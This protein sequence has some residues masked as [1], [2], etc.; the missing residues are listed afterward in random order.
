MP[1]TFSSGLVVDALGTGLIVVANNKLAAL[2]AFSR[3]FS[4]DPLK[5]RATVQ[6]RKASATSAAQTNPTNFETGDTT[7]DAVAVTVNQKS[8]SFQITNDELNKGFRLAQ[9]AQVNANTFVNAISDVWTP[10]L[11]AGNFPASR[12]VGPA[13]TFDSGNLSQV[14]SD[15]KNYSAKNLVMDGSHIGRLIPI[16]T[17][18]FQM[19]QGGFMN[20]QFGFDLITEQNRWTGATANTVGLVAGPDAIAVASGLPVQMQIEQDFLA[21][22]TIELPNLKLAVL[23]SFWFARASRTYWASYDVMFGAAPGDTTQAERLLSA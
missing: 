3:D 22:Q 9:L 1:N 10:L 18:S 21:L 23:L 16:N 14:Y 11:T 2:R 12:N 6:V 4:V 7:I 13:A 5:P 8:K 17:F 15:A 19:E 20:G